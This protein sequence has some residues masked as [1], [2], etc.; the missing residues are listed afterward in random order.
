MNKDSKVLVTGASGLVGSAVVRELERLGFINIFTPTRP[1][2]DLLHSEDAEGYFRK[3]KPDYVIHCAARVGGIVFHRDHPV[4]ALVENVKIA[5]N[6]I[7]A[8]ANTE[9][10]KLLFLGSACA[11]PKHAENP[12]REDSLLTGALEPTNEG[13][14]LAKIVGIKLCEA[15]KRQYDKN[16]ISCMPTNI[17]GP[18]DHYDL[19]NSHVLPGMLRRMHE[20]KLKGSK[21]VSLWGTGKPTRE[22]LHCDDLA[23]ACIFLM[24]NYD[25]PECL[26]IGTGRDMSLCALAGHIAATVDYHGN[27]TWDTEKPDGTPV[28]QL[29]SS[30]IFGLGWRPQI[31]L[32]DGLKQTYDDFCKRYPNV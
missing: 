12:I 9:V 28:R 7:L 14:A 3:V 10:R 26:N 30:K 13:Y 8:A 24:N 32:A 11:Y 18:G 21:S 16:F 29:D 22:F 17:Y 2:V 31:S 19:Q 1:W 23:R 15:F 5:E 27:V 4:S 6:V 25:G 20:A